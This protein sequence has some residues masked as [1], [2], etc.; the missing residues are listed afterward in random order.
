MQCPPQTAERASAGVVAVKDAHI[1]AVHTQL[2]GKDRMLQAKGKVRT[3]LY[4]VLYAVH[5]IDWECV[6]QL[7]VPI[8][9]PQLPSVLTF[10]LPLK[11]KKR[12]KGV[13]WRG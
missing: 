4:K 12:V 11:W 13:H 2:R 3:A 7:N 5:W 10:N 9:V 1:A 8:Q 6:S